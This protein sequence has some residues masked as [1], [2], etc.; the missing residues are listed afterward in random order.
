MSWFA[1]IPLI[2]TILDK[3]IPDKDKKVEKE[4]AE[5]EHDT[6]I[7]VT[8]QSRVNVI[9]AESTGNWLQ[10]SWRP[11]LIY[12]F[13]IVIVNN[14]ILVP[15]F[16]FYFGITLLPLEFP[17]DIP[18]FVTYAVTGYMGMRSLEKLTNKAS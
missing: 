6:E 10:R 17:K 8:E 11:L 2:G 1:A 4:I 9:A 18:D 15:V 12:V 3:L 7:E 13:I 5:I 14:S 16:S